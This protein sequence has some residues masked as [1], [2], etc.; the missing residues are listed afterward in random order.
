MSSPVIPVLI[1]EDIQ[2]AQDHLVHVFGFVSDGIERAPDGTVVHGEVR[3]GDARIWL[4]RVSED[5]ASPRTLTQ[6]NGGLV[7]HVDDV[8]AHYQRARDAGAVIDREPGDQPYGQRG[9]WGSRSRGPPLVVRHSNG[10]ARARPPVTRPVRFDQSEMPAAGRCPPADE[11]P[12]LAAAS[13]LYRPGATERGLEPAIGGRGA[14]RGT[15]G[16]TAARVDGVAGW[17][18]GLLSHSRSAEPR[19]KEALPAEAPPQ[20][21]VRRGHAHGGPGSRARRKRHVTRTPFRPRWHHC[22]RP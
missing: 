3:L 2:A 19:P 18:P 15:P 10:A 4:H 14:L 16:S 13:A 22:R 17:F 6:L 12:V 7:V 11:Q 9:V 20:A 8:D 5:L 1:Y 21:I